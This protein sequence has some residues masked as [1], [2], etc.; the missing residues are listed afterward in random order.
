VC[1]CYDHY[2]RSRRPRPRGITELHASSSIAG[3]PTATPIP[4][5]IMW[6]VN[7]VTFVSR[8]FLC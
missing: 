5:Q 3:P 1:S 7:S 8:A 2:R 4:L 6:I